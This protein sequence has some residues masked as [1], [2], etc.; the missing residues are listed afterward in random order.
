[1]V[2]LEYAYNPYI[3][4][5]AP[6]WLVCFPH[7]RAPPP[8]MGWTFR[9]TWMPFASPWESV[10]NTMSCLK[11]KFR[12]DWWLRWDA[13]FYEKTQHCVQFVHLD[14]LQG[15]CL[16]GSIIQIAKTV[17]YHYVKFNRKSHIFIKDKCQLVV[18]VHWML[19]EP[20]KRCKVWGFLHDSDCCALSRPELCIV[21]CEV[22]EC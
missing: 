10:L 19:K 11:S 7:Q 16:L 20:L 3:F 15:K 13:L 4:I 1:M 14:N 6:S 5:S 18:K 12:K 8:S 9:R 17:I 21:S 22:V 2:V